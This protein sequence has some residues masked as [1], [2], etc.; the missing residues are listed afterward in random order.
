MHERR[1]SPL[2]TPLHATPRILGI[3]IL[4]SFFTFLFKAAAVHFDTPPPVS[5]PGE[6]DEWAL[7][8]LSLLCYAGTEAAR[9][10]GGRGN[11]LVCKREN[12]GGKYY[13]VP[14]CRYENIECGV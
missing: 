5:L 14:S 1:K 3:H 9:A 12:E 8:S 6:D 11:I 13:K 7:F 10:A 2:L 4:L